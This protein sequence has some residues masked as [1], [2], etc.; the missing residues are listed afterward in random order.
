[1][2]SRPDSACIGIAVDDRHYGHSSCIN[3]ERQPAPKVVRDAFRS[4]RWI[5]FDLRDAVCVVRTLS[6]PGC[7]GKA[8]G[9]IHA[10]RRREATI[11]EKQEVP[12]S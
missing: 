1:M 11:H 7:A 3:R 2:S 4:G 9:V 10:Q 8:I 5:F 12:A 6:L